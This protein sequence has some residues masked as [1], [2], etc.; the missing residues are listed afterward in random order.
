VYFEREGYSPEYRRVD[1]LPPSERIDSVLASAS[2]P[3]GIAP[4]VRLGEG[5][6]IDGGVIDN[7]PIY[8]L[9]EVERCDFILV[10]HLS[11]GN[12]NEDAGT[13]YI[14]AWQRIDRLLKVGQSRAPGGEFSEFDKERPRY[15]REPTIIP[16]AMPEFWP[17]RIWGVHPDQ[18]LGFTLNFRQA[19]IDQLIRMGEQRG[20]RLLSE[21]PELFKAERQAK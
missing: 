5:L 4:P 7:T 3:F 11:P 8:P 18:T 16:N 6:R 15:S 10:L 17:R 21:I 9:V 2:L 20:E 1:L 14:Q 13:Q 12:S 19:H